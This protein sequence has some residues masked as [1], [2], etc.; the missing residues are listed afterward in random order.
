MLPL[1]CTWKKEH[2]N[3]MGFDY[4]IH[5]EN[6][7]AAESNGMILDKF[8]FL[9]LRERLAV[10]YGEWPPILVFYENRFLSRMALG[11]IL[12]AQIW[13]NDRRFNNMIWERECPVKSSLPQ[14]FKL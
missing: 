2:E 3:G 10:R 7:I 4:S 14:G 11:T 5:E 6:K 8:F 1:P 9:V 12:Q 13:E